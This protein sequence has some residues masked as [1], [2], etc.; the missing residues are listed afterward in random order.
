MDEDFDTDDI[1]GMLEKKKKK[2]N[3]GKK[4]KRG[5]LGLIEEL[6][7]RFPGKPFSRTLGSGNRWGQAKLT[8]TAKKVFTGDIVVPEN[9][10][11]VFECKNG[12]NTINLENAIKRANQG[13]SGNTTLNKFLEQVSKDGTRI[14][15]KPILCWKKDYQPWLA[16]LETK[17]LP[18]QLVN[19][20]HSKYKE[21]SIFPLIK[22]LECPDNFF[23][24][25]EENHA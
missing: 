12:Y 18:E 6:E 10:F 19:L 2:K 14:Q 24:N 21:W 17:N 22:L 15:R 3:S 7:L 8:E 23:F 11:F 1:L 13:K 9:C 16:F 20:D 5:E 4:G 25:Q